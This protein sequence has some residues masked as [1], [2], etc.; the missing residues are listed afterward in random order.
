MKDILVSGASIA[1]PVTAWWLHR[2]GFRPVLVERLST[3]PRGGHA[4][5]VRGK[6]LAV[7][8]AMDLE[9]AVRANAM[10][11]KGVSII[12]DDGKEVWRS[13]EMTI[14]G[15][16]LDNPDIEILRD[17][18]ANTLVNALPKE[19]PVCF[20]NSIVDVQETEEGVDVAFKS[21]ERRRFDLVIGAEGLRSD[22]RRRCFGVDE[23]FLRP[24]GI[25]LAPFSAPNT[26]GLKDWQISYKGAAGGYMV[27]PTPENDQLRVC[28]SVPASLGED[29]G[30]RAEQMARVRERT[31]HLG[32]KTGH[33]LEAMESAPDFYLGLIAQVRMDRWSKGRIAVVGDAAYCP[34][35]Y[36]GQGATL[37]IVGGF[38]LAS[39]IA[40]SP[41]DHAAAF[42]RYE[43]R[44]RP[45]VEL[46]QA[47]ADLTRDER[48]ERDPGYYGD[49]VVPAIEK[50][51]NA[52]VLD[53]GDF[54]RV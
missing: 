50:A 32:W 45:F 47:I 48:F 3:G 9:H 15:G 44:M 39:E 49:I 7:L 46:N 22:L 25:A 21:G 26:L 29:L 6:A 27:Y 11:M 30:N 28:F 33:F 36:S 16:P 19:V 12:D 41:E 18:L 34:S 51:K 38:V 5:D 35:P 52:I 31:M 42:A 20:G 37:A 14:S 40:R 10:R 13:E 23:E 43:A 53:P 24:F 4:I 54:A 1:G 17:R 2:F 8:E